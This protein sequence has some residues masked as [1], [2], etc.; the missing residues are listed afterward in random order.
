MP[1]HGLIRQF[2]S[3][4]G[5]LHRILDASLV[6]GCM[7]VA[8][9]LYGAPVTG[10]YHLVSV[11]AIVL[12]LLM[13]E[14]RGV[15]GSWRTSHVRDESLRIALVWV[16][17]VL[18]LVFFGFVTKTTDEYS[19]VMMTQWA[20]LVPLALIAERTIFRSVLRLFREQGFNSRNFAIVGKNELAERILKAVDDE[21]W[22]GMHLAGI[23]DDRSS[24]R[25]RDRRPSAGVIKGALPDLLRDC[26][27]GL[28]DYV[29]ISLP[30]KADKR[31]IDL[32]KQ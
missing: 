12:Y 28:I 4:F 5:I 14:A 22:M 20:I 2:S 11:W 7:H 30:M 9:A 16:V 10:A 3:A 6:F 13:A 18:C 1:H 21:K 27:A 15:Y 31:I 29:Y 24:E 19:R 17:V 25:L 26:R 23:Y 8:G 32:V